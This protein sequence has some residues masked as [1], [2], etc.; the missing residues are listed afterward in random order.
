MHILSVHTT[1]SLKKPT[2]DGK[3]FARCWWKE[4]KILLDVSIREVFC[5]IVLSNNWKCIP[6]NRS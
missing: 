5:L 2:K 6:Q 3:Y 4:K 1:K